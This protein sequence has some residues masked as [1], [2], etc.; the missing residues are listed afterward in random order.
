MRSAK[1]LLALVAMLSLPGC[2][3]AA[4]LVGA[5]GTYGA[6]EY[7]DNESSRDFPA[8]LDDTWSATVRAMRELGY[9]VATNASH[10]TTEGHVEINDTQVWVEQHS[11]D[12]TRVRVRIGTFDTDDHRR[13]A[14]LLLDAVA[15]EL[16]PRS[17]RRTTLGP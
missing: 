1:I 2:L 14:Q 3:A 9:P 13:R 11:G 12:I 16:S 7:S 4:L 10:G 8:T 15:A 5:G 17:S 6:I